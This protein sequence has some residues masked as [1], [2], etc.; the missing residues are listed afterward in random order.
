MEQNAQYQ[1]LIDQLLELGYDYEQDEGGEVVS[2][3]TD[4]YDYGTS[5]EELGNLICQF[6]KLRSISINCEWLHIDDLEILSQLTDLEYIEIQANIEVE[7]LAP[8][9]LLKKL[10][11]FELAKSKISDLSPIAAMDQLEVL[12]LPNAVISDIGVVAQLKNLQILQ[13]ANNR[14]YDISPILNLKKLYAVDFS[15]NQIVEIHPIK[16]EK[17]ACIRLKNN[18]I[19]NLNFLKGMED[20]LQELDISHNPIT[21]ISF[22]DNCHKISILDISGISTTQEQLAKFVSLISLTASGSGL[23]DLH[24]LQFLP[25]IQELDVS[26][27]NIGNK[28]NINYLPSELKTLNLA[29]NQISDPED[30]VQFH[31]L[32]G[33]Y[34][35]ELDLTGNAFGGQTFEK[36]KF[37]A[38]QLSEL[39][40]FRMEIKKKYY[41][42]GDH[43]TLNALYYLDDNPIAGN[44]YVLYNSLVS[45]YKR[46][47]FFRQFYLS[48]CYSILHR[49]N[50]QDNENRFASILPAIQKLNTKYP[51]NESRFNAYQISEH[52]AFLL[53]YPS[54]PDSYAHQYY[55]LGSNGYNS[56][57]CDFYCYQQ[58]VKLKSPFRF[59]LAKKII[60]NYGL[61]S[62]DRVRYAL[63]CR[64]VFENIETAETKKTD[65]V[66]WRAM[67]QESDW[68]T[69]QWNKP[70]QFFNWK[71][72]LIALIFML[73]LFFLEY[74]RSL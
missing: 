7:S 62:P 63:E 35:D 24:F 73:F 5:W 17:L 64:A 3:Y 32:M 23:N 36:Y 4:G 40:L 30:M 47:H 43:N 25:L 22:L 26:H 39:D 49:S 9:C 27:N 28:I 10:R 70:K 21:D 61:Y 6:K 2:V 14:I 54:K 41:E 72:G 67:H 71:A 45:T 56:Y 16:A 8:I 42:N 19:S 53:D 60:E 58:L 74:I 52:T 65:F 69:Q 11:H 20:F 51:V 38:E 66:S 55:I 33:P 29:H 50:V 12:W 44:A 59:P 1:Q 68:Q 15:D 46:D 57:G 48:H 13:L 31:L 34:L 18:R 37:N